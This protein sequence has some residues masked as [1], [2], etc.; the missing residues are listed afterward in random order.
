M[1]WNKELWTDINKRV[2]VQEVKNS[3]QK[4]KKKSMRQ[5]KSLEILNQIKEIIFIF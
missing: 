3:V 5:T 2:K 1:R 4:C